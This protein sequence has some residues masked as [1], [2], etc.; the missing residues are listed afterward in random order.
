MCPS[1]HRNATAWIVCTAVID[2]NIQFRYACTLACK[3]EFECAFCQEIHF[4]N[5]GPQFS[6]KLHE[7]N[8]MWVN[9][10]LAYSF[11]LYM[12]V[13][14]Q[15]VSFV[16]C[17]STSR[18]RPFEM[19]NS[20]KKQKESGRWLVRQM[21]FAFR[22]WVIQCFRW[23]SRSNA[24]VNFHQTFLCEWSRKSIKISNLVMQSF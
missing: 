17:D 3:T 6:Q 19:P 21:I 7:R 16:L 12:H 11:H 15:R 23:K 9:G 5:Y 10:K 8:P 14:S 20:K 18:L 4:D 1:M 2:N 24:A 13:R 22:L